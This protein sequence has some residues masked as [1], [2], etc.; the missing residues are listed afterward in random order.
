MSV[1]TNFLEVFGSNFLVSSMV[2]SMALVVASIFVFDPIVHVTK[3]FGQ[4]SDTY[5]LVGFGLLLFIFTMIIGFTL[6]ALNTYILKLFE[7]YVFFHRVPFM[8]KRM[9]KSQEAKARR[10]IIQREVLKRRIRNCEQPISNTPRNQKELRKL[11]QRYYSVTSEYDHSFPQNLHDILPTKFGN[12]LKASETYS[13]S[14]YGFEGVEFWP[15]LVKVIPADYKRTID[16]SRNELSFLINMSILSVGFFLLCLIAIFYS[17]SQSS[18]VLTVSTLITI[19][20]GAL[21][22][23]VAGLIALSCNWFF[24]RAADFSV[25][26]FGLMVRSAYDLFRLDLLKQFKLKMPSNSIEEFS[27]WKELNEFIVMGK[28]SLS[29]KKLDY[30]SEE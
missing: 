13:G 11:K 19:M 4:Q 21:R 26:S 15:R 3:L 6:T 24:N 16:N 29:F 17:L 25:S 7:G 2:P 18:S 23:T 12:I 8:Y 28:H 10:L 9:R 14:R 20:G 30:H 1:F 5:Q 22:Y 27:T